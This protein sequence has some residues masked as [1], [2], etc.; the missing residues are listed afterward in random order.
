MRGVVPEAIASYCEGAQ[1]SR[2]ASWMLARRE[3]LRS[4]LS[5]RIGEAIVGYCET[6]QHGQGASQALPSGEHPE[7]CLLCC[8]PSQ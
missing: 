2:R 5:R 4:G 6:M 8:A 3:R 7:A 1:Q